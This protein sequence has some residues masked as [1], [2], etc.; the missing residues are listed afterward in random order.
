MRPAVPLAPANALDDLRFIRQTLE[1]SGSFTAV[2][3]WGMVGMAATAL[4]A[5]A[6]AHGARFERWM[7]VWLAEA[8]VAL[9]LAMGTMQR[10]A[11][12]A[13]VPLFSG[14]GRRFLLNFMPPMLVGGVLTAAL[15]RAGSLGAIPGMWLLLYGTAVVS[16][17]AFSVRIVPAMGSCFMML[18]GLALLAAGA[19]ENWFMLAGFCGLHAVFGYLIARR[20]GG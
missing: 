10:K 13:R 4:A 15:Y 14:P 16:G 3:G 20:H 17:G 9:A 7:T 1:N 18:G 11:R 2:P 8:V 19:W 6:L 12:R 5:A